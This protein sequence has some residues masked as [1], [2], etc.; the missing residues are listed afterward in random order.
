VSG[1][2]YD[3]F[4]IDNH[5]LYF[6]IGDVSGKG[7]S[8][9]FFMSIAQTLLKGNANLNLPGKIV[10]KVNNEL[11]TNNQH[12]FF[13]TLFVG[14][15][16]FETKVLQFCN[17]GHPSTYIKDSAG[18]I[19]ELYQSHGMPLGIYPNRTYSQSEVALN[20]GDTIVLY[21]DGVTEMQN[22][23]GI[24]FGSEMLIQAIQNNNNSEA[25]PYLLEIEH[26]L[27]KYRGSAKPSDDVTLMVITLK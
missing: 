2:L 21:S 1:D 7:I 6:A 11:Y 27:E 5:N 13:L 23:Q 17:A 4:F 8:A 3:F 9:A 20:S 10:T 24:H 12:Q 25:K 15:I 22:E 19:N 16:N 14:V 26:Q 18:S